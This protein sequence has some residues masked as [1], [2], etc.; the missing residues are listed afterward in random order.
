[1]IPL[2]FDLKSRLPRWGKPDRLDLSTGP[3]RKLTPDVGK[4]SLTQLSLS[5]PEFR[6]FIQKK[7]VI[8]AN[9]ERM[10]A[11]PRPAVPPPNAPLRALPQPARSPLAL[12]VYARRNRKHLGFLSP[13]LCARSGPLR[14]TRTRCTR[15]SWRVQ[16]RFRGGSIHL[17]LR[18]KFT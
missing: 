9:P 5:F 8:G 12:R 18:S 15:S 16:L 6:F 13:M 14:N 10:P 4:C 11:V 7:H 3:C 1:M 2:V 17:H